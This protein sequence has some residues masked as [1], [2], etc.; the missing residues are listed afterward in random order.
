MEPRLIKKVSNFISLSYLRSK[1]I[2]PI[3]LI[4]LRGDKMGE[5]CRIHE[6]DKCIRKVNQRT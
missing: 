5:V 6:R 1:I 2:R 4:K 3:K